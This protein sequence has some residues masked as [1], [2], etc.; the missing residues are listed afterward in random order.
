[1][2]AIKKGIKLRD[3]K[4]I[5]AQAPY[6]LGSFNCTH[7]ALEAWN[8]CWNLGEREVV[9]EGFRHCHSQGAEEDHKLKELPVNPNL[10]AI[11][12]SSSF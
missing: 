5:M 1:M 9:R 11:V 4:E 3:L 2:S 12:W 6:H 10:I 7:A 8:Y